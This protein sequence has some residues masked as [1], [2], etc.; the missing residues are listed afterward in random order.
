MVYCVAFASPDGL[1]KPARISIRSIRREQIIEAAVAIIHEQGLQHLSLSA[2]EKKTG[3]SRGQLTYYF[4]AKEDILLAVFD[5]MLQQMYQRIGTPHPCPVSGVCPEESGWAWV[6][7]LLALLVTTQ[8][9]NCE[10]SSLQYTFLA[11]IAHREDFRQR[12]AT[13]YETWRSNMAHGLG[14]D[15]ARQGAAAPASPRLLASLVQGILHGLRMQLDADPG[16]FD[17]AEMVQLCRNLLGAYLHLPAPGAASSRPAATKTA[18]LNG[19]SPK[20]RGARAS[21]PRSRERKS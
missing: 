1:M 19:A 6:Q 12:L 16:A 2:I 5:N 3:M 15:L 9:I 8:P 7:H 4:K 11:Q 10:F 14:Q 13:L 21:K 18:R 20:V 17:P